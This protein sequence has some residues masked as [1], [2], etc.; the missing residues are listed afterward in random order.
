VPET[1]PDVKGTWQGQVVAVTL[2]DG[3]GRAYPVPVAALRLIAGT[4]WQDWRPDVVRYPQ[5]PPPLVVL[6]LDGQHAVPLTAF[7]PGSSA[8]ASG[9]VRYNNLK[10]PD[11][12]VGVDDS[13]KPKNMIPPERTEAVR[14]LKLA[15]PVRLIPSPAAVEPASR[16]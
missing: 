1:H 7:P 6:S 8:E 11:S 13:P 3:A 15:G 5:Q 9:T 2:Y 16:P 12:E 10:A 4:P 14:F